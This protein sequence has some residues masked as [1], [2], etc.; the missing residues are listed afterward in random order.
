MAKKSLDKKKH[1]SVRIPCELLKLLEEIA[2]KIDRS[3]SEVI[4]MAI[5]AFVHNDK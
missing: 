2:D 4:T 5:R 1:V 3:R